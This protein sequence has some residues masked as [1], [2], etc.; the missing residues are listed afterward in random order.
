[1]AL[2]PLRKFRNG[3]RNEKI[4]LNLDDGLASIRS[5]ST[6]GQI[7]DWGRNKRNI[8]DFKLGFYDL[9]ISFTPEKLTTRYEEDYHDLSLDENSISLDSIIVP[10][11]KT[12]GILSIFIPVRGYF[13][14]PLIIDMNILVFLM[15][16]VTGVSIFMPDNHSLLSWGANF[17][18]YT[19]EGQSWRL[20][21]NCFLHIGIIHLLFNMYALLY[22]AILLEPRLGSWRFGIAYLVTGLLA[23]VSSLYW[24]PMTI[25]AGASGAIFGMYGVFLAMLTTNLIEKSQRNALLSSITVFVIFNLVNGMKGGIDN[26]AHIGGLVSGV[27]IGYS[28]YPGLSASQNKKLNLWITGLTYC[29]T[30]GIFFL[31]ISENSKGYC[32]V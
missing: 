4:H 26:A 32:P 14:T 10:T 23:S 8:D 29:G 13:I 25:S 12:K 7:I 6:G 22:V 3:S 16:A 17:R 30:S 21:T 11:Q 15:M 27:I 24:H 28:F 19:M 31:G 18:P 5:E 20:L 9:K 1:M 2:L